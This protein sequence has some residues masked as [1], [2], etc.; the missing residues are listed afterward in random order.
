MQL[1]KKYLMPV[2]TAIL[3]AGLSTAAFAQESCSVASTPVSRDTATGLTEVAGDLTFTC[4]LRRNPHDA[5]ELTITVLFIPAR[6]SPNSTALSSRRVP[7]GIHVNGRCLG[8]L[9]TPTSRH[10]DE[11][12]VDRGAGNHDLSCLQSTAS[13]GFHPHWSTG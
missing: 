8:V 1:K 7:W 10:R 5:C 13:G 6:R 9:L 12:V 3:M 4:T 2:L 11:Y